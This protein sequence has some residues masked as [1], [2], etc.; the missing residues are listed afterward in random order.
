MMVRSAGTLYFLPKK[1]T[2]TIFSISKFLPFYHKDFGTIHTHRAVS[3]YITTAHVFLV[4]I[5]QLINLV[6]SEYR[7]VLADV[8]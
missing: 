3:L 5:R 4:L 8:F 1:Y 7:A 6:V 2:F